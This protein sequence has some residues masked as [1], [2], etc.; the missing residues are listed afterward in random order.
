MIR[1]TSALKNQQ[2]QDAATKLGIEELWIGATNVD[3]DWKWLDGTPLI[4]SNFDVLSGFPKKTESQIGAASMDSLTGMWYTKLDTSYLPFV[5]QFESTDDYDQGILYRAPKKQNLRFPHRGLKAPAIAV[6]PA[7]QSV[8]YPSIGPL[9]NE[10]TTGEKVYLKPITSPAF[11]AIPG[12]MSGQPIVIMN[13]R[14]VRK[15]VK[16]VVVSETETELNRSVKEKEEVE[17]SVN[18]NVKVE[19][20]GEAAGNASSAT[21]QL[22]MNSKTKANREREEKEVIKTKTVNIQRGK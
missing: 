4:Y 21:S 22:E 16:P 10:A 15:P 5:C 18:V 1:P 19:G 11:P 14:R 12:G 2:I 20:K 17:D 3:N 8:L 6:Q 7:D 9:Q 13:P